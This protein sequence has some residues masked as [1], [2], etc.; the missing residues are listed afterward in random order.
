MWLNAVNIMFY[1]GAIGNL[2]TRFFSS[3]GADQ[4]FKEFNK[5]VLL[6]QLLCLKSQ[7]TYDDLH[8]FINQ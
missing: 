2:A 6:C 5:E 1:F 3:S 8:D 7:K 4:I